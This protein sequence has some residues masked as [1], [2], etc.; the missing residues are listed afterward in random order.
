MPRGIRQHDTNF[1]RAFDL[2]LGRIIERAVLFAAETGVSTDRVTERLSASLSPERERLLHH[3]SQMRREAPSELRTV[4]SVAVVGYARG[5]QAQRL[6]EAESGSTEAPRDSKV[7]KAARTRWANM[8]KEQKDK[9]LDKMYRARYG[10]KRRPNKKQAKIPSRMDPE[11]QRVYQ[12]RHEAKKKGLPLPP[13][14]KSTAQPTVAAKPKKT[15]FSK[16]A[17][18]NG[19]PVLTTQRNGRPVLSKAQRNQKQ[20]IYVQ[21]SNLRAQGIPEDQLPALPGK[22]ATAP[23]ATAV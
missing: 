18:R 16:A 4:E 2:F 22:L 10:R 15:F 9:L 8:S 1:D 14:P 6:I 5:G 17:Q 12:A 20:K 3:L 11:V 13:L 19:K 7:S 23:A 21:R